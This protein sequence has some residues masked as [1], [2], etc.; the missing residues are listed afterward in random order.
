MVRVEFHCHTIYS[1]DSLTRPE[2]LVEA[3]R[4]K[5]I[6]RVIVTD[7]NSIRGA[8]VAREIDPQR[9][10]LGEEIMTTRGELLVAFVKEQIPA[11]LPPLEAISRLREQGAFISVSHPFD[12]RRRGAWDLPDLLEIVPYVDAIETFNARCMGDGPNEQ[13]QQF[14]AVRNLAGTAG[15][16]AHATLE[17]GR[18]T[19]LLP[20]FTDAAG[21]AQ[22]LRAAQPQ[23]RRSGAWVH[24]YSLFAKWSKRLKLVPVP[25]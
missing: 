22:A 11:G 9:V 15:S 20:E 18:A 24:F 5:G 1:K 17:L 6:D 14:A 8:L 23:V 12:S 16:D 2:A 4:R 10:I 13:A 7:H 3:C 21:L 25:G 19:L